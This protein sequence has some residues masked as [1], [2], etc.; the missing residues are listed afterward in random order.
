MDYAAHDRPF[1]VK[2][3]SIWGPS[4]L[5]VEVRSMDVLNEAMAASEAEA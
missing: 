4:S 1:V 3:C 5:Q 2:A